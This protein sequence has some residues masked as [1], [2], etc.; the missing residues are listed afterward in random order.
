MFCIQ[1]CFICRPWDFFLCTVFNTA[2]FAASQIP[3]CRRM[4][5]SAPGLLRLRHWQPDALTLTHTIKEIFFGKRL[6]AAALLPV[7]DALF[8]LSLCIRA[9]HLPPPAW[10][11]NI[12]TLITFF[13]SDLV[14]M[15]R[16]PREYWMIYRG[17]PF[18]PS[19]DLAPPPSPPPLVSSTGD[20]QED[21]ERETTCWR[22]RGGGGGRAKSYG[23]EKAWSSIYY[24]ILSEADPPANLE[25]TKSYIFR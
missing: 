9:V 18:S 19:Y 16:R 12:V 25:R 7:Q 13:L 1:H 10:H 5:G 8:P 11:L 4:L 20:T 24:S 17:Q 22:E 3:L 2:S 15:C 6:N 23:G 21:R 14:S